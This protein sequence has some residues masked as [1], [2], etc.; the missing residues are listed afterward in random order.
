MKTSSNDGMGENVKGKSFIDM[1]RSDNR[2]V[3]ISVKISVRVQTTFVANTVSCSIRS[4][5][6][7]SSVRVN[8]P[9]M[10]V[11]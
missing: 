7:L 10:C 11:S 5:L 1:G 8:I 4:S 2:S 3:K 6:L 9:M